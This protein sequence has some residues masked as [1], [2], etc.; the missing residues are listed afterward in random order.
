MNKL[1]SF[2]MLL[3]LSGCTAAVV[4]EPYG[5][6]DAA[7]K[8]L[9][10][11]LPTTQVDL[12]F[13]TQLSEC[14]PG[15]LPSLFITDVL[16]SPNSVPDR[17]STA[18]F[19]IDTDELSSISKTIPNASFKLENSMLKSVNYHAKD[20][21]KDIIENTIVSAGKLALAVAGV[22]SFPV[23]PMTLSGNKTLM[24]LDLQKH[25]KGIEKIAGL[26]ACTKEVQRDIQQRDNY[27]RELQKLVDKR[28]ALLAK[29][30]EV[31]DDPVNK[32]ME[33]KIAKLKKQLAA[34]QADYDKI[35]AEKKWK[36]ANELSGLIDKVK[37]QVEK[38]ESAYKAWQKK[39][40]AYPKK[41][42]EKIDEYIASIKAT[43]EKIINDKL[44][45]SLDASVNLSD[46]NTPTNIE[47]DP[48]PMLNWFK[49]ADSV[50]IADDLTLKASANCSEQTSYSDNIK[51]EDAG[52]YYRVPMTCDF[53]VTKGTNVTL[54]RESI[55]FMQFGYLAAL[56]MKNIIF[57]DN[58]F[59]VNFDKEGNLIEFKLV[60][61]TSQAAAVSSIVDTAVS[62][63]AGYQEKEKEKENQ[64]YQ[65]QIDLIGKQTEYVKA[66]TDLLKELDTY[67]TTKKELESKGE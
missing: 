56:E 30:Y 39:K 66:Q 47:L 67:K 42:L 24:T 53:S 64:S 52:I 26:S 17:S 45:V 16:V 54:Y 57:Q 55:D 59:T 27:L 13:Q 7:K 8:G 23:D 51:V 14:S 32:E 5:T 6:G 35:F 2:V 19:L 65:D 29:V 4:S 61:N 41:Q 60:E 49:Q 25:L 3:A 34:A 18:T 58:E 62:E 31:Q 46:K 43:L 38:Q 15:K 20:E 11:Q 63:Y 50:S 33:E 48:S 28:D 10:Y 36:E 21:S 22:P 37:L 12:S 44:T 1:L 40:L 9:V